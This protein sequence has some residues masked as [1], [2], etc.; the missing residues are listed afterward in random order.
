[1]D[2]QRILRFRPD[3]PVANSQDNP[4]A[5]VG[6]YTHRQHR[7]KEFSDFEVESQAGVDPADATAADL[8]QLESQ[9]SQTIPLPLQD[10]LPPGPSRFQQRSTPP[11]QG[12]QLPRPPSTS[13]SPFNHLTQPPGRL[14]FQQRSISPAEDIQPSRPSGPSISPFQSHI[15]LPSSPPSDSSSEEQTTPTEWE[16]TQLHPIDDDD[17]GEDDNDDDRDDHSTPDPRSSGEELGV[18]DSPRWEDGNSSPLLYPSSTPGPVASPNRT[19]HTSQARSNTPEQLGGHPLPTEEW[20]SSRLQEPTGTINKE[21]IRA[22]N[23]AKGLPLSQIS[24]KPTF[25]FLYFTCPSANVSAMKGETIPYIDLRALQLQKAASKAQPTKDR[26][27]SPP[28]KRFKHST[29]E[30]GPQAGS[31]TSQRS[32]TRRAGQLFTPRPLDVYNVQ[33]VG[34]S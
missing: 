22:A 29:D 10:N 8:F 4:F 5:H 21:S 19:E 14:A 11:M 16:D 3:E 33:C 24:S 15:R 12:G 23:I 26:I 25:L 31:S 9:P 20:T 27:R 1:M 7:F 13:V 28:H 17:T 30:P 18:S 34:S 2:R 32:G 6:P